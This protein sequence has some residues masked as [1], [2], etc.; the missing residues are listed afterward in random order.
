MTSRI[1]IAAG[2]S[3]P[4]RVSASGIDVNSA[5]FDGLIFDGNQMPL[6]I[7]SYGY[8]SAAVE[9]VGGLKGTPGPFG[10]ATP[11]GTYPLFTIAWRAIRTNTTLTLRTVGPD[12]GG[13]FD[14]SN[15]LH[16]LTYRDPAGV[17]G[18]VPNSLVNYLIFR[19]AG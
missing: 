19:N 6:R 4:F 13:V 16:A 5:T 2:S 3:S 7:Y 15:R 11:A 8:V 17:V 10:P 9:T 18:A 12:G 1:K 14:S